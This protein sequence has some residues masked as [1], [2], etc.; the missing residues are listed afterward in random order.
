[1]ACDPFTSPDAEAF[2]V[3]LAPGS[4]P[5]TLS[6]AQYEDDDQRVAG[7]MLQVMPRPAVTWEMALLPGENPDELDADEVYGFAVDSAVGCLIDHEA[8]QILIDKMEADEQYFEIII[9]AMDETY[10][11]TWSWANLT[12]NPATRANLLTFSTGMGDGLYASYFGRDA[13]GRLVSLVTDFALFETDEM[14]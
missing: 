1:M 2:T 5:L 12:M 7:A 3:A 9:R 4:Y 14:A 11:D 13:N 6:I 8:A 10:V